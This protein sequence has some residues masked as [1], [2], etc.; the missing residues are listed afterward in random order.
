MNWAFLLIFRA[1]KQSLPLFFLPILG[2]NKMGGNFQ[3]R[4]P[5][6]GEWMRGKLVG[7]GSFGT[8]HMALGKSTG[9]LFVVKSAQ[10][11]IGV[12]ALENEA[13][14]L[15]S[16]NSPHIV[17]CIGKEFSIAKN[18]EPQNFN[19]FLEYMAGGNLLE[20]VDIFGGSRSLGEEVIRL[21]TREILLGLKYLH[22][23]G[24]VHC[25]LKCKNV[26]LSSSGNVKLADFGS[27]KRI[28][29]KDSKR[30]SD[31]GS[32][33]NI[34]GTPLWMA[35]EVL[36][37]RE[38]HFVSDIWS[39]GCT[40]IE[41]A[42]GNPPWDVEIASNSNPMAAILK[43][44]CGNDKPQFPREFSEVGL[45]FLA[46]CLERDPRKRW[47]ADELL[48]HPFV[49]GEN[50][51]L[52]RKPPSREVA[53]GVS[54]SPA[55]VLD[56]KN[57]ILLYGEGSDSDQETETVEERRLI[58]PFTRRCHEGIWMAGKQQIENQFDSSENWITVR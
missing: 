3:W 58:N 43:I 12:Q 22:E 33:Q 24:I 53:V 36:R 50:S 6:P 51:M 17:H 52:M 27:A 2:K 16:L 47:R 55:S 31:E 20:L 13:E 46:K 14:I 15:E 35:P 25:D 10:S 34:G 8:V 41:L 54:C 1:T 4:C 28:A 26:L 29:I 7:S 11:C 44:A 42:T 9:R 21:Y 23:N 56:I 30:K 38:L 45:D 37:N 49:S 40:V 5:L 19:V 18:G 32:W 57:G 39:L 48:S